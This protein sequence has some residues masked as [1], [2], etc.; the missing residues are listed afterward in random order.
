MV[1][2]YKEVT[3]KT[4]GRATRW[5]VYA[6]RIGKENHNRQTRW[7]R[8]IYAAVQEDLWNLQLS[9]DLQDARVKRDGE[10][11][12]TWPI[13]DREI[14]SLE[15]KRREMATSLRSGTAIA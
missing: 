7:N 11:I 3:V 5:V 13:S 6:W 1:R 14:H 9:S 12:S 10:N 4:R 2:R 8:S 15:T